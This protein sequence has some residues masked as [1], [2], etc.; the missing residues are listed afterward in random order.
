MNETSIDK[1]AAAL[2]SVEDLDH[3][4]S[5]YVTS[6]LADTAPALQS[7]LRNLWQAELA[8]REGEPIE[9]LPLPDFA[10]WH[11]GNLIEAGPVII[12]SAEVAA[13]TGDPELMAFSFALLQ[14]WF[15][16]LATQHCEAVTQ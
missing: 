11:P 13:L 15:V 4:A 9:G 12:G 10:N 16:Q 1:L 3:L 6:S 5:L 8:R 7:S 2:A 14:Y